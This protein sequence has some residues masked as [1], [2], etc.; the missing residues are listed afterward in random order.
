MVGRYL[1][2]VW[3]VFNYNLVV[4]S[5]IVRLVAFVC[6]FSMVGREGKRINVSLVYRESVIACSKL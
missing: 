4:N 5:I 3:C 1:N 2:K 6:D